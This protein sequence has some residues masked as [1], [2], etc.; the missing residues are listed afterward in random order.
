MFIDKSI[1]FIFMEKFPDAYCKMSSLSIDADGCVEMDDEV[2]SAV[3]RVFEDIVP[4]DVK[5]TD[6]FDFFVHNIYVL[7]VYMH[8]TGKNPH[9]NC[10]NIATLTGMGLYNTRDLKERLTRPEKLWEFACDF[11]RTYSGWYQSVKEMDEWHHVDRLIDLF[12]KK[13]RDALE[14]EEQ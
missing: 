5:S 1:D 14:K 2:F 9:K 10:F 13:L 7:G 8:I 3:R 6:G 12:T 4:A 11:D